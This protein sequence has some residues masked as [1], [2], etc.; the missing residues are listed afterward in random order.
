MNLKALN[1]YL[2]ECKAKGIVP[3]VKGLNQFHKANKQK[4]KIS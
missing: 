3:T 2:K 4:Y 1:D